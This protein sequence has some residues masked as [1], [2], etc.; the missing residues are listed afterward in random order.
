MLAAVDVAPEGDAVV[1]D[2]AVS[3]ERE[4]LK[5]TRIR[6][7]GLRPRHETVEATHGLQR[8]EAGAQIEVVGVPENDVGVG[9]LDIGRREPLH[10]T[11]R[12]DGHERGGAQGAAMSASS[13]EVT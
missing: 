11:H 5:P 8:L 12:A 10:G 2:R 1:V 9:R 7:D 13:A 4:H 3:G 6:Q